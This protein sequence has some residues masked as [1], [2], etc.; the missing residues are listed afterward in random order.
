MVGYIRHCYW[1]N[2]Y[3]RERDIIETG[4]VGILESC[5][6]PGW[7]WFSR[8]IKKH[9]APSLGP[10]LW[11]H[12]CSLP[13]YSFCSCPSPLGKLS[14]VFWT[15]QTNCIQYHREHNVLQL[16]LLAR[17]SVTLMWALL[18]GSPGVMCRTAQMKGES[19]LSWVTGKFTICLTVP[20]VCHWS[21]HPADLTRWVG[22]R[23]CPSAHLSQN[24]EVTRY[25]CLPCFSG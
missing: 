16:L 1:R 3:V 10:G 17:E 12:F 18:L 11:S 21:H 7:V 19:S 4:N 20:L 25:H 9:Q 14:R 24:T 2:N 6:Q 22:R 15:W 13:A 8:E 5:L 23:A